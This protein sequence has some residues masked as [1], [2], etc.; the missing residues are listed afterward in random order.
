MLRDF[1]ILELRTLLHSVTSSI[2]RKNLISDTYTCKRTLLVI[3]QNSRQ[4]V[5]IGIKTVSKIESV[6]EALLNTAE[7]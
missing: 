2:F 7:C 5:R 1:R 4:E 6:T 3:T